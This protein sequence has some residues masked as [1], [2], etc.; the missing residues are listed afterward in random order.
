MQKSLYRVDIGIFVWMDLC[1]HHAV[2]SIL[3]CCAEYIRECPPRHAGSRFGSNI[4]R[5]F[6]LVVD[7]GTPIRQGQI[8]FLP[9]K[10]IDE[11]G[12]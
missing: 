4:K 9:I 12:K 1:R 5:D 8:D 10:P 2:L 11:V 6:R 3:F 7:G